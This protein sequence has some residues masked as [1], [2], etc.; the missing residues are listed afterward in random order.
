MQPN[1]IQDLPEILT[2]SE[3]AKLLRCSWRTLQRARLAGK[4]AIPFAMIGERAMYSKTAI[5][6]VFNAPV[7]DLRGSPSALNTTRDGVQP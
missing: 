1:N 3:A 7:K 6:S 2:E 5:L 4:S